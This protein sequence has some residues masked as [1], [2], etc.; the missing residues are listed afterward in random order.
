MNPKGALMAS[1]GFAVPFLVACSDSPMTPTSRSAFVPKSSFALNDLTN[2]VAQVG[3]L[4]ICKLGNAGGT[5]VVTSTPGGSGT[6]NPTAQNPITVASGECRVAG[7]DNGDATTEKGDFF[8]VSENAAA[9]TVGVL[10]SCIGIGGAAIACNNQYFTN[11]VHGTVLTY[12]NTFTPPPPPPPP[13]APICD[14]SNFGGFTLERN[15]NISYGGNAGWAKE[16]FAYG[17]LNFVNHTTGDHIHVQNVTGYEHPASGPLSNFPDSRMATGT[18]EINE[19]GSFPVEWRFV[20]LGEPGSKDRVYLKVNGVVLI[21]EQPVQGGNV[22][23]H[24]KCKKAPK[25]EKH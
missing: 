9:N 25:A 24:K 4:K 6:G 11:N 1:A 17:D 22:Q 13:P 7:I 15:F 23:L 12:T 14:F 5:F 3:I 16:G 2:D 20:D 10:T 21:Q 19:S 8:H 18:G